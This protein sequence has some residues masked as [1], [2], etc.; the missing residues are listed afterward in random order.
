MLDFHFGGAG[1][2]RVEVDLAFSQYQCLEMLIF[3]PFSALGNAIRGW[4]VPCE[5]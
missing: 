2:G 3:I 4:K 5:G 1:V